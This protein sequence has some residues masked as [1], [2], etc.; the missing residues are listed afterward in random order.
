MG[1]SASTTASGSTGWFNVQQAVAWTEMGGAIAG[2]TEMKSGIAP[3]LYF[4]FVKSKF[5]LLERPKLDGRLKRLEKAFATAVDAGQIMLGEKIMAEVIRE[6][7]ESVLYAK[8]L[9]WFITQGDL[10]KH[11]K[12]IRG[13]HISDTQLKDFTRAI[14]ARVLKEKAK[15]D[16]VFDGF[17]VYHYW[18]EAATADRKSMSA[19]EKDKMRDPILFGYF[20]RPLSQTNDYISIETVAAMTEGTSTDLRLYFIADWEDEE[21]DL[22][23]SEMLD[24]MGKDYNEVRIPKEPKLVL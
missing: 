3:Q 21:C 18:S 11:K 10:H 16:G 2:K 8:G 5:K 7:R 24:A 13:G 19:E 6:T 1:S 20:K 15:Y 22:S 4:T 23:F 12:K 9:K 17:V 14:P